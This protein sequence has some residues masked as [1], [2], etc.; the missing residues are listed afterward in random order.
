MKPAFAADRT[1]GRLV[2]WLRLM[3]FDTVF[4]SDA[5]AGSYKAFHTSNRILL[6]RIRRVLDNCPPQRGILIEANDPGRQIRQVIAHLGLDYGTLDPFTRCLR[7][8]TELVAVKR[9]DVFGKV[10]DYIWETQA[11]FNQCPGCDRIF[12]R[13]SHIQRSGQRLY[14]LFSA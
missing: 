7:C 6:T 3:G 8:N 2:K 11:Q 9:S 13:G 4:E 1:L 10:P 14:D 5:T 12:W